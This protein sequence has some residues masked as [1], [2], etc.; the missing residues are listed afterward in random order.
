MKNGEVYMAFKIGFK[1]ARDEVYR[2]YNTKAPLNDVID[3]MVEGAYQNLLDAILGK[4]ILSGK[5]SRSSEEQHLPKNRIREHEL[6][7]AEVL[8]LMGVDLSTLDTKH[9]YTV[10]FVKKE[11]RT[12]NL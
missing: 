7:A 2:R 11:R 10:G 1:A 9:E 6:A 3:M 5:I 8:A 4:L 12:K